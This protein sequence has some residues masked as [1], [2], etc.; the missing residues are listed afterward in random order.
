MQMM[1]WQQ[2]CPHCATGRQSGSQAGRQHPI[3]V[4]PSCAMS[5]FMCV[6]SSGYGCKLSN[7]RWLSDECAAAADEIWSQTKTE[8]VIARGREGGR[9][10][11]YWKTEL[12]PTLGS[13]SGSRQQQKTFRHSQLRQN[14][15]QF[16]VATNWLA[17]YLTTR[18]AAT[19]VPPQLCN[20][21]CNLCLLQVPLKCSHCCKWQRVDGSSPNRNWNQ[22]QA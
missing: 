22:N 9:E 10:R 13:S 4:T 14:V 16:K 21:V 2:S 11:A 5:T 6:S 12:Q 20:C 7:S 19:W 1:L 8:L 3:Q 17:N 18:L 15:T